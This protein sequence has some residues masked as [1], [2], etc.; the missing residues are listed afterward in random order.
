MNRLN[1]PSYAMHLKNTFSSF[2]STDG[3]NG[4][5]QRQVYGVMLVS[6]LVSRNY[7]F[8]LEIEA[9]IRE[10]GDKKIIALAK[11]TAIHADMKKHEDLSASLDSEVVE[12]DFWIYLLAATFICSFGSYV[13]LREK[14]QQNNNVDENIVNDV[15]RIAATVQSISELHKL[16]S[17][18]KR[19]ILVVDDEIRLTRIL[20]MTLERTGQFEVRT[21]NCA[22]NAVKVAREFMPDL[23]LLDVIMPG[24][25]GEDVAAK[26]KED[27]ELCDIKIIFL[28]ALLTKEETGNTGK[29][30]G[31]YLFLA[32]PIK[33]DD[34]IFCI[35]KNMGI[36]VA[37]FE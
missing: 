34:L 18:R 24:M 15:I 23:I 11:S 8:A 20:K 14:L 27:E 1:L 22:T 29:K 6:A 25:G 5:E 4:L 37:T 26:I 35:D 7:S 17:E 9:I 19:K 13:K 32:K 2:I 31:R 16:E 12:I 21:E 33:D 28:T 3:L 30:I 36:I 10:T